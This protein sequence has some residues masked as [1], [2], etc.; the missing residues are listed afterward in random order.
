MISLIS[1]I[2]NSVKSYI[3]SGQFSLAGIYCLGL[4][5]F[6]RHF[7]K[8]WHLHWWRLLDFHDVFLNRVLFHVVEN[9]LH[10]VVCVQFSSVQ[11]SSVTQSGR[12]FAT[13][14]T[15]ARQA[16]LSMSSSRILLKLMSIELVMPSNNLIICCPL[17]SRLQSFPESESF[18][19]GQ[20]FT[21]GGQSTGASAS[22][23]VLPMN[24]QD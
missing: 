9:P 8:Q 20:F 23:S 17:L 18:P 12:L 14:W 10:R 16:S 19:M 4:D 1:P 24:I 22:A 15:T 11:F 21:S 13:P 5:G 7:S 3:T 6:H 2:V